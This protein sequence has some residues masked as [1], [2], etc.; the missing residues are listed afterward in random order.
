M[1]H[2][3]RAYSL[4]LRT[5]ARASGTSRVG[6][7]WYAQTNLID[8]AEVELPHDPSA[9]ELAEDLRWYL[10]D[11][12]EDGS[13]PS[14]ARA[15]R[16]RA[17][18]EAVGVALFRTLFVSSPDGARLW[19]RAQRYLPLTEIEADLVDPIPGVP[20]EILQSPDNHAPLA[21]STGSFIRSERTE[22]RSDR[23]KSTLRQTCRILLV[24]SRPRGT[25]DI[26]FRSVGSKLFEALSSNTAFE[27]MVLRPPT[28]SACA[29]ALRDAARAGTPFDIVHFDGHGLHVGGDDD[30]NPSLSR[31]GYV[32][33]ENGDAEDALAVSGRDFGALIAETGTASVVLNACRS[34]YSETAAKGSSYSPPVASFATEVI[35]AGAC[36]VVA[37]AYDLYVFSAMRFMK[38]FYRVLATGQSLTVAASAAR[39]HLAA[40]KRT[41]FSSESNILD[42]WL[43]PRVFQSP[44]KASFRYE[45]PSPNRPPSSKSKIVVAG[46]ALPPPPDL[47]FVGS[48]AR[49]RRPLDW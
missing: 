3:H 30:A 11:F 12:L 15:A 24:I 42:D 32:L 43:V 13:A 21:L 9:T 26:A 1:R 48:D 8:Q 35:R 4:S 5:T 17:A 18:I 45:P 44:R 37:M 22:P 27:V 39:K 49:C 14:Q 46:A 47:G 40:D 31:G 23:E 38:E 16:V 28:F 41:S 19:K 6:I 2:K 10:E 29:E 7:Y 25:A 36:Q 33:F 34:S 20:W